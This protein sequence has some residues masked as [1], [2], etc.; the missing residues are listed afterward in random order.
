MKRQCDVFVNLNESFCSCYHWISLFYALR[1]ERNRCCQY[2]VRFIL[3]RVILA[4]F[5]N[6]EL[7]IGSDRGIIA[8]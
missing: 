2:E 8:L 3:L 4:T 7:L 6:M 5:L 1:V